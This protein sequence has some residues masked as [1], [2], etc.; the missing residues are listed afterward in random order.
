MEITVKQSNQLKAVA[1]LFMLFLHLFNTLN[2]Q[3]LFT[4]LV[5]IGEKPLVYYLS[6]FGDTCVPVF[7]FVSGYGLYYKYTKK[8]ETYLRDNM[9]RLKKI[10]LNYWVI[11]LL[12][13]VGLGLALGRTEFVGPWTRVLFNASGIINSYNGA[14]WFLL[15]YILLVLTS[16]LSFRWVSR[17]NPYLIL[18]VSAVL[19]IIAFYFR[20]YRPST[21]QHEIVRW[22]HNEASLFGTSFLPFIT[23]AVSLSMKWQTNLTVR[24]QHIK[25]KSLLCTIGIIGLVILHALVPNFI[26]APFLAIPFIF[27]FLQVQWPA[28]VNSLLDF[29]SPHA[30]NMWLVHMFFYITYFH[31]FIFGFR[32]IPLIFLVL[33]ACSIASSFIINLLITLI[34]K[35]FENRG[36]TKVA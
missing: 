29:M 36:I 22:V 1:I 26:I 16:P 23:G 18:G 28:W 19:Y 17:S 4:P 11:L 24:L 8:P 2:F 21:S 33:V 15:I 10:Y 12:F 27:L 7:C 35:L 6:L 20:V 13:V 34:G 31:D 3:G 32:Y 25:Y 5:F 14:W 9:T 30:T